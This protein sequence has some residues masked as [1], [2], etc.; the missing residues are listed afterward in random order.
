MLSGS[1]QDITVKLF[2]DDLN[3][4]AAKAEEIERLIQPIEGVEDI[5]VEKVTGLSQIQVTYNRERMAQ[6]GLSIVY[7]N[8]V[9][10]AAFAGS[11]AGVVYDEEKRFGLVV[12]LDKDYRQELDDVR[13]LGVA[14]PGGGQVPLSEIAS[15]D[16]QSGPAQVTR[17]NTKRRISVGFNVRNRDIQR[18]IHDVSTKLEASVKLPT[19]YYIT[20]GGQ[21][22]NLLAAKNRLALAVP[23]ALLLIVVLLYFT[24]H[25]IKQTLLILTAVPLSLIG[26][27]LALWISGMPFSISAGVGFIALF[28]I[29]VLNGIVLIAE[30]NRLEREEGITSLDERIHKGLRSR[31]R[32]VI[33]TASVAS[34]GF[35]PMALSTSAGAEV[36]KP[37]ATVVI[38]GLLTA[39]LLTLI[40]LPILY[41]LV[42]TRSF[43]FTRLRNR[44]GST[45]L[46]ALMLLGSTSQI[47]AQ[48]PQATRISL[49]KAI[50][51]ALENNAAVRA[52]T[53]TVE[54]QQALTGAALD[55]PKTV[56]EGSYGHVNSPANDNSLTITQSFAFPTV[57]AHQKKVAKSAE[58]GAEWQHEA[59]RLDMATQVR[60]TYW[61]WVYQSAKSEL[62]QYQDSLLNKALLAAEQK[63]ASGESDKL[64]ALTARS[65]R[66]E[67]V[68]PV[69]SDPFRQTT[70][71][72]KTASHT[73]CGLS[74]HS[75]RHKTQYGGKHLGFTCIGGC[76]S[77][78]GLRTPAD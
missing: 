57:Y 24:F 36:Q 14:L 17:D 2:G 68:K 34:M 47:T 38:G 45:L 61:E 23:I 74:R 67:A 75:G 41:Q 31:L 60:Q 77:R 40:I 59:V 37:L 9:L 43:R 32:P 27:I 3:T 10:R 66:L 21:F 42:E 52:S 50:E 25:S 30:F 48:T 29:A 58:K 46:V 8:R 72:S 56:I 12:R 11:Q 55:I 20:Y 13:N 18:V 73:E 62:Y 7:A 70:V 19:G 5:S 33:M 16:I 1:K 51:L 53:Y 28:G 44:F 63:V 71:R 76:Q 78:H 65:Q 35:L 49:Q 39:T 22:E 15:V 26:G 69:E 54:A 6:Y 4:L 64:E